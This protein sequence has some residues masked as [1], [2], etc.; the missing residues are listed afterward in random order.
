MSQSLKLNITIPKS[1]IPNVANFITSPTAGI[2]HQLIPKV[3]VDVPNLM[4]YQKI[5]NI[6]VKPIFEQLSEYFPGLPSELTIDSEVKRLA[7]GIFIELSKLASLRENSDQSNQSAGPSCGETN[8]DI[9]VADKPD[10]TGVRPFSLSCGPL[11]FYL[12]K[13]EKKLEQEKDEDTKI[14]HMKS[15]LTK[16]GFLD[17]YAQVLDYFVNEVDK[18][19]NSIAEGKVDYV[20]PNKI[21]CVVGDSM[22]EFGEVVGKL[23]GGETGM[24]DMFGVKG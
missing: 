8:F 7:D 13:Y 14:I 10:S 20:K 24:K 19:K 21:K 2:S 6:T 15:I 5:I 1:Q 12:G 9:K 23:F 16:E 17:T 4:D 11:E 22:A 3:S 18:S